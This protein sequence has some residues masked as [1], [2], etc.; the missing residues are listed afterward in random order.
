MKRIFAFV[1]VALV[2]GTL[3][4][5]STHH[6]TIVL[7]VEAP[8]PQRAIGIPDARARLECH[9]WD[10]RQVTNGSATHTA[11]KPTLP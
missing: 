10:S 6:T 2:V 11:L 3:M 4:G 1:T 8:I 5:C 9:L 7:S